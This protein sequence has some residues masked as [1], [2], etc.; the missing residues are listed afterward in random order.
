MVSRW[1]VAVVVG[2]LAG[3]A[4]WADP[5]PPL[6][7]PLPPVPDG[8]PLVQLPEAA[9]DKPETTDEKEVPAVL[10][11]PAVPPW[12][13]SPPPATYSG[14][15][16]NFNPWCGPLVFSPDYQSCEIFM[17]AYYSSSLG[18]DIPSFD[19]LPVTVRTGWMLTAPDDRDTLFRGNWE[20][21][22]SLTAAP[23]SSDYGNY[24][25][26]P[27]VLL[28]KNYLTLG[29]TFVPYSQVGVGFIYSDAYRDQ[30]QQAIGQQ[31]QFHVHAQVGLRY[32]ISDTLSLAMEGGL[33]HIS[34][35]TMSG[36]NLGVNALGGQV[37]ITYHFPSGGK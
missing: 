29:E 15:A 28:R 20:C 24:L 37:G 21:L 9:A 6:P 14:S 26:G 16:C 32:F 1:R 11:K 19:Y 12:H 36:R 22:A 35:G 18:P 17:G 10:A 2:V 23:I 34:C 31:F 4:L 3:G 7:I 25:V 30:T 5:Y 8:P 27:S 33:Q 13:P